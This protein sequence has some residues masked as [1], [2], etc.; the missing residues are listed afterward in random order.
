MQDE[1]IPIPQKNTPME[2][3]IYFIKT[4]MVKNGSI[5][6]QIIIRNGD[7]GRFV[8]VIYVN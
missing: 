4:T 2:P 8:G 3:Y 6:P 1:K 7:N 5:F